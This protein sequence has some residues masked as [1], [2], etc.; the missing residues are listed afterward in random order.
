M[1]FN[2]RFLSSFIAGGVAVDLACDF[3]WS[4]WGWQYCRF[5]RPN[6]KGS[7]WTRRAEGKSRSLSRKHQTSELPNPILRCSRCQNSY[8]DDFLLSGCSP[9]SHQPRLLLTSTAPSPT[10]T[11]SSST[12]PSGVTRGLLLP[13]W[14]SRNGSALCTL[15]LLPHLSKRS[16]QQL[17]L[18]MCSLQRCACTISLP[19]LVWLDRIA[20]LMK[21][22]TF[23]NAIVLLS[24]LWHLWFS[25]FWFTQQWCHPWEEASLSTLHQNEPVGVKSSF[26]LLWVMLCWFFSFFK[27]FF[28]FL[29]FFFQ[30]KHFES[31]EET[32]RESRYEFRWHQLH[33]FWGLFM[34]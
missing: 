9:V 5:L 14:G 6:K 17:F 23:L 27:V 8:P 12:D 20:E 16:S 13:S 24:V 28:F 31:K 21:T 10:S 18:Q 22:G 2:S 4:P 1:C 30:K 34:H 3:F 19:G 15:L 11:G 29:C 32:L 25:T 7:C 26:C 33:L